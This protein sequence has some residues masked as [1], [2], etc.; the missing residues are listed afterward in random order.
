MK[1]RPFAFA[2]ALGLTWG[3]VFFLTT[4]LSIFTGYANDFLHVLGVSIYPGY[5]ITLTG[6]FIGFGYAFLDG[7]IMAFLIAWIYNK[8]V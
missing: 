2:M 7:F 4:W 6:A 5:S 8:F 3:V 1:L